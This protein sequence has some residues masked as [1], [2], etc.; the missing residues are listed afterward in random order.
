[1]KVY[2]QFFVRAN[3]ELLAENTA[4]ELTLEGD[5]KDVFT[6]VQGFAGQSVVPKKVM[7]KLDGVIPTEASPRFHAWN[8]CLT[9]K[10]VE[11]QFLESATGKTLTTN[12]F[13]R[14]PSMQGGVDRTAAESYEFHGKG[15]GWEGGVSI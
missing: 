10:V 11:M 8:T 13:I 9:S 3:G 12:G 14:K 2:G 15:V 6:T 1:M 5:D 7:C 4:L